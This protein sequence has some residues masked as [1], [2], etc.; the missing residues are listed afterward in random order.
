MPEWEEFPLSEK[1]MQMKRRCVRRQMAP[2]HS[3]EWIQLVTILF[4]LIHMG[5][6]SWLWEHAFVFG[7][8]ADICFRQCVT[9]INLRNDKW[10]VSKETGSPEPF[11]I[12][13]LTMPV[14]QILQLQGDIGNGESQPALFTSG[15][16]ISLRE[17][18]FSLT[19][20]AKGP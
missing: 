8:G 16:G 13:V 14:P 12:V 2:F 7:T 15:K 3:L 17:H 4:P 5:K 19:L 10:E 1:V 11:D 20:L 9:Q 6:K 18:E